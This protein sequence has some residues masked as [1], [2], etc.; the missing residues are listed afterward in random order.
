VP[1]DEFFKLSRIQV[2]IPNSFDEL[3][4]LDIKKSA[5]YP[6]DVIRTRLK[7]LIPYFSVTSKKTITYPGRKSNA[8]GLMPIWARIEPTHGVYRYSIDVE[9]PLIQKIQES[10]SSEEKKILN[11][12][13]SI[14]ETA[15]PIDAI[16]ADMC[17][18][19][20]RT[21]TVTLEE[22]VEV[23]MTLRDITKL[24]TDEL[25]K[26]DPLGRHPSFHRELER[27]LSND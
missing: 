4:A 6:P 8:L 24:P 14:I 12:L 1:K 23:A 15:L 7:E 20:K 13:F 19:R 3:W 25:L 21:E 26:I 18:D 17:E 27:A 9:H 2:D 16:Y 22:L 10:L 5:A 11:I